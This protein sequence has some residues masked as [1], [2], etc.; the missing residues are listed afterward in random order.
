MNIRCTSSN[1][2]DSTVYNEICIH[3]SAVYRV[4]AVA[5]A[6]FLL[7]TIIAR[8]D[9]DL[10][11]FYWW[12]KF[13]AVFVAMAC[14]LYFPGVNGSFS[15]KS[16]IWPARIGGFIFL[17]LQQVILL[18]FAYMWN[19]NWFSRASHANELTISGA[20][21]RAI[22]NTECGRLMSNVWLLLILL[23]SAINFAIFVVAMILLYDFYGGAGCPQSNA[24]ITISLFG[25]LGAGALQLLGSNG[26]VMTTG[27]ISLYG[28]ISL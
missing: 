18:D 17:I 6:A 25:M 16:Y 1:P 28:N 8:Y 23:V 27:I 12:I 24:I 4:C 19:E 2:A 26:S 9:I 22:A 15:N 11:D 10:F 21:D 14:L 7:H 20:A 3:N 5:C 13:P